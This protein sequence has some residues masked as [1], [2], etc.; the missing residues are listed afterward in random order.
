VN[1]PPLEVVRDWMLE[2]SVISPQVRTGKRGLGVH[3][4]LKTGVVDGYFHRSSRDRRAGNRRRKPDKFFIIA[5][6]PIV[7]TDLSAALTNPLLPGLDHYLRRRMDGQ[8]P[9]AAK[10]ANTLFTSRR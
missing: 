3:L 10:L 1:V 5:L 4:V 7:E 6:S 9:P 8:S 2:N